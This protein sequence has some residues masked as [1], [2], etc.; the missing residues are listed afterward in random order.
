M[1]VSTPDPRTGPPGRGRG[2]VASL[3]ARMWTFLTGRE[4]AINYTFTDM[5]IE[6]PRDT[7]AD[8]PRATWKIDGTLQVTTNDIDSAQPML[9]VEVFADLSVDLPW[10]RSA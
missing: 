5:T 9:R 8:A 3:G 7:G 4:A 6:V 10:S 1:S 2:L